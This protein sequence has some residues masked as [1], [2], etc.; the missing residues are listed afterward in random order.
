MYCKDVK[1]V[2]DPYT[3]FP[4]YGENSITITFEGMNLKL[5]MIFDS[6]V[7]PEES[8]ATIIF[9][10]VCFHKFASF[11]GIDDSNIKIEKYDDITSLVEFQYSDF[12]TSWEKHFNYNFRFKHYR[13]IFPNA[14][15]ILEV[16]CEDISIVD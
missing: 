5:N 6:Q 13:I 10:N 1:V 2:F 16:V 15:H 3:L 9:R 12:K 8:Y 11:P 7:E 4:S 14:N